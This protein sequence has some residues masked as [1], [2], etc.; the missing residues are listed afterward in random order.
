MTLMFYHRWLFIVYRH[1]EIDELMLGTT[2]AVQRWE[3]CLAMFRKY[4]PSAVESLYA[5]KYRDES[6]EKAAKVFTNEAVEYFVKFLKNK[7]EFLAQYREEAVNRLKSLKLL[8]GPSEEISNEIKLE[9]FYKELP[10]NG[11]ENIV[12]SYFEMCKFHRKVENELG[13]DFKW[14][15]EEMS[16]EEDVKYFVTEN[17]LCEFLF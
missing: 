4:M 16:V 9:E 6:V 1:N 13:N 14:K 12:A 2:K 17:I 11:Q 10:L 7:T 8:F 5:Q 3:Q 15:L